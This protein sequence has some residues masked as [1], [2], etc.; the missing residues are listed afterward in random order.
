MLQELAI[1][2][3]DD[4]DLNMKVLYMCMRAQDSTGYPKATPELC[5]WLFPKDARDES[6][7]K[8]LQDIFHYA[9]EHWDTV[10]TQWLGLFTDTSTDA[11][12]VETLKYQEPVRSA[13]RKEK[14]SSKMVVIVIDEVRNLFN[15][16]PKGLDHFRMLRH[17][18]SLANKGICTEGAIFGVLVDTNSRIVD[19]S[20][21][22]ALDPAY[23][24]HKKTGSELLFPPFVLT[25]TMDGNWEQYCRDN[26]QRSAEDEEQKESGDASGGAETSNEK[27]ETEL[28][29][30]DE[31]IAYKSAVRGEEAVWESLRRMGR[32]LWYGSP[33]NKVDVIA[34]ASE[35][36]MLGENPGVE[37]SYTAH[38]MFGVASMLCR[39]GVRPYLTSTLSSRAVAG[40]MATLVYVNYERDGFLSCYDSDP[41]LT[42]GATKVWHALDGALAKFI[43]PQLSKL[44]LNKA[45]DTGGVGEMVAR[46]VMLLAMDKCVEKNSNGRLDN[47]CIGQFVPLEKF[48]DVLQVG[49]MSIINK[50]ESEPSDDEKPA[51]EEWLSKWKGWYVGYTHFVQ[52]IGEPNEDTLWFLLGRRAA[53]V[54]PPNQHGADLLIPILRRGQMR[55]H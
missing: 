26:R 11:A 44:I 49:A 30:D 38:T 14:P 9:T 5:D 35:K 31:I 17:A 48:L 43:L 27:K 21:P 16:P 36:L 40:F 20:P 53:G 18:L 3:K 6:I 10:Q 37:T 22:E 42:F 15:N 25:H 2:A 47:E 55:C 50:G 33:N 8:Q 13:N 52:L 1:K 7:A 51:F 46:I 19:L 24:C 34:F 29:M 28:S 32:P 23:R 45:L 54:F 4:E 39:L 41:V 12:V